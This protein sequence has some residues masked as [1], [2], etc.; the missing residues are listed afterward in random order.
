[1][2]THHGI[3]LF[4]LNRHDAAISSYDTAIALNPNDSEAYYHR[5]NALDEAKRHADA[6]A[7]FDRAIALGANHADAWNNRGIAL[8]AMHRHELAVTSFDRALALREACAETHFNRG[9]ALN[10][11][12]H[13]EQALAAYDR[14][15]SI[16]PHYAP[17]YD[18]R[19]QSLADLH[20]YPEAIASYEQ[21]LALRPD[22]PAALATRQYLKMLICDWRDFTTEVALLTERIERGIAVANPFCLLAVADSP[23]LQRHAAE[24]WV[25]SQHPP[26]GGNAKSRMRGS[27]SERIRIGYFSA[28]FHNHATMQLMAGL[29]ESHD[30]SRFEIV[31]FSFGPPSHDAMRERL[32]AACAR[33][34]DIHDQSDADAAALCRHAAIDLAIDLKGFTRDGRLGIFARR[35]APLQVSYLGY[36]GTLGAPYID[37]LVADPIVI[38]ASSRPDYTESIVYLPHSYQVNDRTRPIAH[39]TPTREELGLP[40]SGFVFCCFNSC[41]KI[42]PAVFGRW[43]R[44]LA[45]NVAAVRNLKQAASAHGVQPE[46]LVFARRLAPPEHL[47]RHRCADLALDT[48]PCGAHTTAS[49]ALWAGLPLLT[50]PG[51]TFASRVAASL[52]TAL[53]LP[54]LIVESFTAYEE[55]AVHLA[56]AP[57]ILD[58]IRA[59]LAA[60]RLTSPLF[61]TAPY[62]RDLETA[63]T[64]MHERHLSGLPPMDMQVA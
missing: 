10:A 34:V 24:R 49:D 42:T 6:T 20:R 16:D 62:T 36:P 28:D 11:L 38:P 18:K 58:R 37:Y 41:Y 63:Y 59:D 43:M 35:A 57:I 15:I 1:M 25:G 2:H 7:S 52:L 30:R 31:V 48:F 54:E 12:R 44:I 60:K 8:F 3:A 56:R 14:C 26:I 17:A 33:F 53:G 40:T 13:C 22:L 55:T 19:A 39:S 21:A 50:Q 46:R 32:R 23:A 45:D 5:G 4:M 47:A 51:S 29:F 27:R 9:N 61:A 64:L